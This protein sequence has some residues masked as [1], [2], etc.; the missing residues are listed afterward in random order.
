MHVVVGLYGE[1]AL[2]IHAMR[3]ALESTLALNNRISKIK[4]WVFFKISINILC[5]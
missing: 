4:M 2:I 3:S 1:I 5:I